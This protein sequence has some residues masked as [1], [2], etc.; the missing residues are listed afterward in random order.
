MYTPSYCS[1]STFL[2][3]KVVSRRVS[4]GNLLVGVYFYWRIFDSL[5]LISNIVN[6]R[7]VFILFCVTSPIFPVK[8]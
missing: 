7:H 8:V 5:G 1:R 6:L 4:V 3:S 2:F